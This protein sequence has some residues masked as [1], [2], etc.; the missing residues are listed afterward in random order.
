VA[1]DRQQSQKPWYTL[2]SQA[3]AEV[4]ANG[5]P[6]DLFSDG[7]FFALAE[8]ARLI[9]IWEINAPTRSATAAAG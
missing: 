6:R 7:Y 5:H 1:G 3:Y 8:T 2:T 9:V 4:T